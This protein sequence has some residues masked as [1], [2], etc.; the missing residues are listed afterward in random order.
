MKS[1]FASGSDVRPLVAARSENNRGEGSSTPSKNA[2]P[3]FKP[4]MDYGDNGTIP[5]YDAFSQ[6]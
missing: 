4:V 3:A 2:K 1:P 6:S 5:S